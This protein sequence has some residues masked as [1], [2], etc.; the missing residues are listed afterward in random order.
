VDGDLIRDRFFERYGDYFETEAE[1]NATL[2]P[3]ETFV[4]PAEPVDVAVRLE[5]SGPCRT[6]LSLCALVED[7]VAVG[8]LI[9]L[10]VELGSAGTSVLTID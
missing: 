4:S 8:P 9:P 5:F 7:R 6:L 10:R 3:R 1:V 2:E